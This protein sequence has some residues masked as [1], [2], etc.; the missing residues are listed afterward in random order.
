LCAFAWAA[1]VKPIVGDNRQAAKSIS[2]AQTAQD[3]DPRRIV[4]FD[5][6]NAG[7]KLAEK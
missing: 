4:N 3:D 2:F 1:L 6:L 5:S 7:R